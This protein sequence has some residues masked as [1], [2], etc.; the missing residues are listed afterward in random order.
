M[1]GDLFSAVLVLQSELHDHLLVEVGLQ[2]GADTGWVLQ[3][4]NGEDFI[5]KCVIVV[6]IVIIIIIIL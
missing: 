1:S 6:V 5:S 3:P 2:D 4:A